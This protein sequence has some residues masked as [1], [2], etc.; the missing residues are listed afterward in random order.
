MDS[1]FDEEGFSRFSDD[2][3]MAYFRALSVRLTYQVGIEPNL[4]PAPHSIARWWKPDA[5]VPLN[6]AFER[7]EDQM[8]QM[9]ILDDDHGVVWRGKTPGVEVLFAYQDFD[10]A[11]KTTCD[12]LDAIKNTRST[13]DDRI[14]AKRLGIYLVRPA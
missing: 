9:W 4:F 5:M 10:Y 11:L 7:V 12:V 13:S 8:E 2:I 6:L 14:A 3:V 1:G